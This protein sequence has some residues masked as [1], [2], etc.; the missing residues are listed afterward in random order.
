MAVTPQFVS[1]LTAYQSRLYAYIL[2]VVGDP[3]AA[4]ELLQQTNLVACQKA[5]R[6]EPGT[7]FE[8][9]VMTIARFEIKAH[10]SR[11]GRERLIFSEAA[12]R[13]LEA[14][15]QRIPKVLDQRME[16]LHECFKTLSERQRQLIRQRYEN[17]QPVG[18]IAESSGQSPSVIAQALYRARRALV[19]CMRS[20]LS[21]GQAS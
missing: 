14:A 5:D 9:W 19:R 16:L 11:A 2:C 6:F 21:K 15:A 20:R 7:D 18:R 3:A 13:Q 1:L 12:L 17:D 4:E 8:A 10:R